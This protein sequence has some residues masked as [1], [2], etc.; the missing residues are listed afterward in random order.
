M[1]TLPTQPARCR[2]SGFT[3]V[4]AI[5]V[6]VITGFLAGIVAVFITVPVQSYA[7]SVRRAELTDAA[8]VILR[9]IKR[10][11][12]LALP[13]SLRVSSSGGVNYIEFILT[14]TGGLY[15]DEYDGSSAGD[16]L[17]FTSSADK[18]FD[19]LGTLPSNPAIA[20]DDFIVVNNVANLLPAN[21]A[22]ATGDP[23]SNCNR[24][25]VASIA[26]NTVTLATN[27]FAGQLRPASSRFQVVPGGVR[28]VTF[29]CPALTSGNLTRY[30]NYGFFPSQ[31][32]AIAALPSLA[33]ANRALLAANVTCMVSPPSSGL[34]NIVLTLTDPASGE[35][36]TL[37]QQIHVD[38]SA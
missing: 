3:L 28:A 13:N 7:D 14:S 35:G 19:V 36:V 15:R 27:P 10:E 21:N 1:L 30:W 29:A 38:N 6:I 26:S 25:K 16:F 4:E 8:D 32:D 22:Y 12:R 31:A 34:L 11:I 5:M 23:C 17:S 20:A 2:Q 18:T 9:R 33:P 24:A 37:F